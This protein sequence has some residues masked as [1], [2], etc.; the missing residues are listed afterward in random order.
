MKKIVR[1]NMNI[2]KMARTSRRMREYMNKL[3]IEPTQE[4]YTNEMLIKDENFVWLLIDKILKDEDFT[5]IYENCM[6][7]YDEYTDESHEKYIGKYINWM[8]YEY[9]YEKDETLIHLHEYILILEAVNN[10]LDIYDGKKIE[11]FAST[12]SIEL[13]RELGVDNEL[14]EHLSN[15]IET[16]NENLNK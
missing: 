6:G 13:L 15:I 7:V 5:G 12:Q 3:N 1:I 2:N 8:D 9:D 11:Y 4:K 10:I 14:L 16:H